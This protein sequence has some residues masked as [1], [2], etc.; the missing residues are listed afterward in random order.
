[1]PRLSKTC[2]KYVILFIR[3]ITKLPSSPRLQWLRESM[4]VTV[5]WAVR[6]IL[7]GPCNGVPRGGFTWCTA[8]HDAATVKDTAKARLVFRHK[9]CLSGVPCVVQAHPESQGPAGQTLR[10]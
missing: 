3:I 10:Q 9:A 6:F 4:G 1:M 7:H 2:N 8:G 5:A